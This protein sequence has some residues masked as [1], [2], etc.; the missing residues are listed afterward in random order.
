MKIRFDHGPDGSACVFARAQRLIIA[1]T[2][3]E[4]SDALAELDAVRRDGYWLAGYASYEL[5]FALEETLLTYM[6]EERRL[7]LLQ[8]GVYDWPSI[9]PPLEQGDAKVLG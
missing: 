9:A 6:P 1:E 7:P 2:P 8:F 3:S 4:V 5:G